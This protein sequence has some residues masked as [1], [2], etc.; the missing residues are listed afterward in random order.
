MTR[1]L[2]FF[3]LFIAGTGGLMMFNIMVLGLGDP[4]F[5]KD[6]KTALVFYFP[7]WLAF[8]TPHMIA[9]WLMFTINIPFSQNQSKAFLVFTFLVLLALEVSFIFDAKLV[10]LVLGFVVALLVAWSIRRWLM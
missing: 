3:L 7:I 2:W 10:F 4:K 5:S 1:I 8:F 9:G 6:I